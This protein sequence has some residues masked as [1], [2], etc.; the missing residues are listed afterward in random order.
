MKD[1]FKV[2]W[3]QSGWGIYHSRHGIFWAFAGNKVYQN[4]NHAEELCEELNK[5]G[6]CPDSWFKEGKKE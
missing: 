1:K 5:T 6:K 3:T 2:K 4:R